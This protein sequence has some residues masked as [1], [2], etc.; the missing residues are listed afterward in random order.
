MVVE[1]KQRE[2]ISFNDLI[3]LKVLYMF[4]VLFTTSEDFNVFQMFPGSLFRLTGKAMKLFCQRKDP[5]WE[6][7][8]ALYVSVCF[9]QTVLHVQG[10]STGRS[11]DTHKIE[12]NY[13]IFIC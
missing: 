10:F 6:E 12:I 5:T 9:Y 13:I 1:I 8:D 11:L 3:L 7:A 2:H 4:C